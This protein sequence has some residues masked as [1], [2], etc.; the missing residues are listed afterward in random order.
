VVVGDS[1]LVEMMVVVTE[2]AEL[3]KIVVSDVG[4]AVEE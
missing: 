4:Y 3:M 2:E 1:V